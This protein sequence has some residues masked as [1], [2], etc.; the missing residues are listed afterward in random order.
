[1]FYLWCIHCI[2][3][4]VILSC[5]LNKIRMSYLIIRDYSIKKNCKGL[6][7]VKPKLYKIINKKMG[8]LLVQE[9]H[10]ST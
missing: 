10:N 3:S 1:M 7:Y 2:V 9:G 8:V 5:S 6:R 4:K